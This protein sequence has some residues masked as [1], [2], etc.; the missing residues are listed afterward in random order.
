MRS[1]GCAEHHC[2]VGHHTRYPG[3]VVAGLVGIELQELQDIAGEYLTHAETGLCIAIGAEQQIHLSGGRKYGPLAYELDL[4][5][6]GS[7]YR[8]FGTVVRFVPGFLN[9]GGGNLNFVT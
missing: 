8:S 9:G 5:S 3:D 6:V 4:G 2:S 1:V 7:G